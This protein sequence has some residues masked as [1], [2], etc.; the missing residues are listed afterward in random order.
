[1]V[2]KNYFHLFHR[3]FSLVKLALHAFLFFGGGACARLF[4]VH[5]QNICRSSSLRV[6]ASAYILTPPSTLCSWMWWSV[7]VVFVDVSFFLLSVC[8]VVVVLCC[9]SFNIHTEQSLQLP[10]DRCYTYDGVK[11]HDSFFGV[12]I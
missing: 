7:A 4:I 8:V 10:I 1:M 5:H 2:D 11:L 6:F 9:Y 3:P 12:C